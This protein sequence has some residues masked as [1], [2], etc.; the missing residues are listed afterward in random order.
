MLLV[1]ETKLSNLAATKCFSLWGKN[2]ITW[3]HRG[4]DKEGGGIL[5]MWDNKVFSC[6][7]SVEGKGFILIEGWYKSGE[8]DSGVKVIVVNVY[9]PCS[10]REKEQLLKEIEGLLVNAYG[11]I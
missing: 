11:S 10:I 6:F 4:I 1:Q 3:I 9:P 8:S 7:G 2:D 5:T